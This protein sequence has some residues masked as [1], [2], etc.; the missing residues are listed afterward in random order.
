MLQVFDLM[1]RLERL[2]PTSMWAALRASIRLFKFDP[3]E[4]VGLGYELLPVIRPLGRTSCVQIFS[5]QI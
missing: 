5:G 4:F 2:Q 3:V 1:A